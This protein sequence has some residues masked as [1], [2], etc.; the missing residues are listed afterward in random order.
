MSKEDEI[1]EAITA[2]AK[3]EAENEE[4]EAARTTAE[5]SRLAVE[6]SGAATAIAKEESAVAIQRAAADIAKNQEDN[7]WLRE[8]VSNLHRN[9]EAQAQALVETRQILQSQNETIAGIASALTHQRSTTAERE[10]EVDPKK[11]AHENEGGHRETNQEAP[12][13]E[14]PKKPLRRLL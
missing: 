11:A 14:V 5:A 1:A 2:T 10:A 3:A 7:S 12:P 8:T 9:S 13:K 4:A 6:A